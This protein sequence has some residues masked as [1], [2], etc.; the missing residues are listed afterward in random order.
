MSF[1]RDEIDGDP[2][3]V[4]GNRKSR[5]EETATEHFHLQQQTLI[6]LEVHSDQHY[7]RGTQ[8]GT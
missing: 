3:R 2:L 4:K 8:S 1:A 6:H 5:K 7:E